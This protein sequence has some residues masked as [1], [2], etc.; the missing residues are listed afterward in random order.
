MDEH[1]NNNSSIPHSK[2]VDGQLESAQLHHSS[3]EHGE[4]HSDDENQQDSRRG[5]SKLERW[6]SH[7][8]RDYAALDNLQNSSLS[9][10]AEIPKTDKSQWEELSKT[11]GNN[12]GD[13]EH[14][15]IDANQTS[16]KNGEDH[17]RHL[18]TVAKL[19]RR[20][21]RFKLPMPGEKEATTTK[22]VETETQTTLNEAVVTD[23]E[24]KP[25]RP[26]RKRRWTSS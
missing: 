18:D 7:K 11:E 14:K 17:S 20:S 9:S 4:D 19:K 2:F 25:E 15:D 16:G 21:E 6:T 24:I 5:R 3:G 12:T 1:E 22:K 13:S 23:V 26:P 10:K 8:E